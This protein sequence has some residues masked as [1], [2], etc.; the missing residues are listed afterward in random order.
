MRATAT[1]TAVHKNKLVYYYWR[2]PRC[3]AHLR[4]PA[5]RSRSQ[6][7]ER[8]L[9]QHVLLSTVIKYNKKI[10]C[11]TN[12][13]L[14]VLV[15]V[16]EHT[17]ISE[18]HLL[19]MHVSQ[20]ILVFDNQ[21]YCVL[22]SRE[23]TLHIGERINFLCAR[24]HGAQGATHTCS[25]YARTGSIR[26]VRVRRRRHAIFVFIIFRGFVCVCACA[27]AWFQPG[28]KQLSDHAC[29]HIGV[30]TSAKRRLALG[31]IKHTR[32]RAPIASA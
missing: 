5:E 20:Y 16:R 17:R 21:L 25:L 28:A 7:R 10:N 19:C 27:G 8:R 2:C 26:R 23:H 11:Y 12:C 9:V 18:L 22:T 14:F 29:P 15:C 31:H 30:H 6:V 24:A 32:A 1:T 3:R 4:A 13:D